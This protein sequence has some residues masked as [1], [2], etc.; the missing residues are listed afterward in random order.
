MAAPE[1]QTSSVLEA[2]PPPGVVVRE[3]SYGTKVATVEPGGAEFI[4]L[5]E[6]HG[7]PLQLFWTWTS[8]NFEF[9][10]VFVGVIGVA[11]FG[12][13]FWQALLALVIGTAIGS[14]TQ[15][16]LSAMGPS[17]GVPQMVLSRLGFGYWGNILP[18]GLNAITAGI[19]W[20]AVNSVS[21]TFALN[22]LTHLPKPLCLVIIVA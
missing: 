7:T 4:P 5:N 20:F 13:N 14:V 22:T 21:G 6:R 11:I 12:L 10:T 19:G 17:H 18:A 2:E 15:G 16:L 1:H 3:G 8:P 9:A